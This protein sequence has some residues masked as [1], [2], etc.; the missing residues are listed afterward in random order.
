MGIVL[1]IYGQP[2]YA[3]IAK[4]LT[5]MV[6]TTTTWADTSVC[7][8]CDAELA[9]PGAGFIDHV[10]VSDDCAAEFDVWRSNVADD[11]TGGWIA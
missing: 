3:A 4:V 10:D 6:H 2:T 1:Y 8:F 7:P 11:V 9:D 5:A